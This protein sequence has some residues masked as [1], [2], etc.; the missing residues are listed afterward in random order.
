VRVIITTNFDRLI[1]NALRE[2]GIEPTVIASADMLAGATPM[3][4]ARCTVI[5][6]HG[7]YLD[8]RIKNTDAELSNYAPA[9][10][11]LLDEVFDRFGLIV[12]G[13]SGEWDT[14]LRAALL[15]SPNRRYPLYW[16]ARGPIAPLAHDL[17]VHRAG[18]SF[19]ID[20]ADSFFSRLSDAV[21][22]LKEAGRPHPQSVAIALAMARRYCRDDRYALEWAEFLARE[23]AGIRTFVM[24]DTFPKETPTSGSFDS[25]ARS[26]VAKCEIFRRACLLSGRWGT[27]EANRSVVRAIRSIG[28][29]AESQAGFVTWIQVRELCACL[30]FYWAVAGAVARDD[31]AT[32]RAFMHINA[33]R[34]DV[35]HMTVTTLPIMALG[36]HIPWKWLNGLENHKLPASDFM[37]GLFEAEAAADAAEDLNGA[38]D[39]FNRVELLISLEFAH[40]RLG[41]MATNGMHFWCPLGRFVWQRQDASAL[42]QMATY[43]TLPSTHPLLQAGLLGGTP[44]TA[45]QA[46]SALRGRLAQLPSLIW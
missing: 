31:F 7:D 22:A 41:R 28:F 14:A 37:F 10:D 2:A 45:A 23:V 1:E 43:E 40:I 12:V 27:S 35:D 34:N 3:I 15:R 6:V 18:R 42:A 44:E 9:I 17:I 25:L 30:C 5:K 32:A 39:L 19:P 13:W 11:G 26:L 29:G 20:D 38:T 24:G 4:H 21:E 16:A 8:T 36:D 46:V 33:R